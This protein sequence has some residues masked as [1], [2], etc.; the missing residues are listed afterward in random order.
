MDWDLVVPIIVAVFMSGF[1]TSLFTRRAVKSH[2][3]DEMVLAEQMQNELQTIRSELQMLRQAQ[4]SS[5]QL[6]SQ[7]TALMGRRIDM[8][9]ARIDLEHPS[10]GF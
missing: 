6:Q 1:A 3:D 8:I 4:T 5:N 9:E 10:R 2:G 7:A